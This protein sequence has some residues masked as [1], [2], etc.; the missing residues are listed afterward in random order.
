VKWFKKLF[1][2]TKDISGMPTKGNFL[3]LLFWFITKHTIKFLVIILLLGFLVL[4][5]YTDIVIKSSKDRNKIII[6]KE[7]IDIQR[8]IEKVIK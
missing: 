7:Q 4:L 5:F 1:S 2:K 8:T 3:A 6:K